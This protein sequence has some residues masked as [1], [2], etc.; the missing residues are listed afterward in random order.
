MNSI[1]ILEDEHYTRR[2]I[3]KIVSE[4]APDFQ[5]FDTAECSEAIEFAKEH[6]P[7]IAL[8]DIELDTNEEMNGLDIAKIINTISSNTKF[9]FITGYPQYAISSFSVH[10]YDYILKPLDIKKI[11]ETIVTLTNRI[12]K[13]IHVKEE[14]D[15][16]I[17]HNGNEISFVALD[18]IL[19]IEKQ[20][21]NSLIYTRENIYSSQQTLNELEQALPEY[22]MRVHK[23]FI[24]NKNKIHKIREVGNRSYE[25][26]FLKMNKVAYM[27]RYKF[28]ELKEKIIPS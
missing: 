27:S 10:P 24:V 11:V 3:R 2:L 18:S 19:F 1:L 17:I 13:P 15:K 26:S 8:L 23:S 14:T 22:F 28:E 5:I 20:G 4:S 16:I 9:V 7:D 12:Q 25:I 21:R 6:L